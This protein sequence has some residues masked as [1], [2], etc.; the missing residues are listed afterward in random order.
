MN[1]QYLIKEYRLLVN[2][3]F[4]VV[5]MSCVSGCT[6]HSVDIINSEDGVQTVKVYTFGCK[7]YLPEIYVNK[8]DFSVWQYCPKKNDRELWTA[9]PTGFEKSY[10]EFL[11]KEYPSDIPVSFR[12]STKIKMRECG[13]S[14]E[15]TTLYCGKFAGYTFKQWK[16]MDLDNYLTYTITS[17]VQKQF[18]LTFKPDQAYLTDKEIS[19]FF[20]NAK[21]AGLELGYEIALLDQGSGK[22][23]F[24]RNSMQNKYSIKAEVF[25]D[26]MQSRQL[27]YVYVTILGDSQAVVDSAMSEFK[28]RYASKFR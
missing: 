24:I 9:G 18:K 10:L 26:V 13:L 1:D 14:L 20:D 5:F 6:F 21:S 11:F 2:I 4:F 22:I 23:S 8:N 19:Q 25:V 27:A 12:S 16:K 15:G 3:I 17:V 28:K 7:K